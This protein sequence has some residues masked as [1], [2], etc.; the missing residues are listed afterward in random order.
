MDRREL[1]RSGTAFV[2]LAAFGGCAPARPAPALPIAPVARK[3]PRTIEQLGRIRTDDYAWMKD[4]RWQEVLNDPSLLRADIRDH[5]EAENA[6]FDAMMEGAA[7]LR[8]TLFQEMRGRVKEDDASLPEGDGPWR[9]LRRF[10]TGAEHP[11]FVRLPREGEGREA[12]LLDANERASGK[13][14]YRLLN[15]T[16]SPDHRPF[17]WAE[18]VIG[19]E[20]YEIRIKDLETGRILPEPVEDAYGGFVF[21]PDSQWLF[22]IHREPNG[23]PSKVMRRP[24]RGGS[25]ETVLVYEETDIGKF[26]DVSVSS[27]RA[28]IEIL[29]SDQE[30]SE[31]RYIPAATPEAAPVVFAPRI[32][33]ELYFPVD[34]DGRWYILTNAAGAVDFK[35]AAAERAATDRKAW[36]DVIPH[37]PGRYIEELVAFRDHLVRL[38]R[39]N[40][41]P[42]IVV[43]ERATS[44]EHAIEQAEEAFALS[45][46]PPAEYDVRQLR[47][48]Y[49]S[50]TTPRQWYD[51]DMNARTSVLRKTQE[52]PSGHDPQRYRVERF[53]ARA[54]DGALV[55]VTVLRLADRD[56]D[57]SAPLLLYGYGSYGYPQEAGF[58][59]RV[60][61]LVDRGWVW[62]Y[63]HV[64]GGSDLGRDWFEQGRKGRKK[65][66]FTDF[67]AVAEN[68]VSR[69]YV[70]RGRIVG[71]G[72]SAGGLLVG[73]AMVFA[74]DDLFGGWVA[75]VPFVDVLNTISDAT[76]PLTPTE[77]PE[78]GN[79]L[80]DPQAYDDMAAYSPYDNIRNRPYPPVLATGG[81]TDPRVTYWEPAKYIARLRAAAPSGGPYLLSMNM[82]AGHSGAG[83]RFDRLK[84]DARDYAFAIRALGLA[85]GGG[86][87]PR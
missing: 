50:P 72:R 35:V 84:D 47:F 9:Y 58:D 79:P 17:A 73:G 45:L 70:R 53:R 1:F 6:Y 37:E 33:G 30:T 14:F 54:Q 76:L 44:A 49:Q 65:N 25:A 61:S 32:E 48:V 71:M 51:Y 67:V 56:P 59:A 63:A 5:L 20:T 36:R 41:L 42:R 82:T 75:G 57:G 83:G 26:P 15:A 22:W 3:E 28:F 55:P 81:L 16:H 8:E 52:V 2:L 39:A 12:I 77:W 4:E 66:S 74:P 23:R 78:W 11:V 19:S 64:R 40:A 38:E 13:A 24:A 18:D 62:A 10:A 60:F 7:D 69:G 46:E 29:I 34:F 68:L 27:S 87:F 86:A 80:T 85:E 31:Y 43:R 21:S